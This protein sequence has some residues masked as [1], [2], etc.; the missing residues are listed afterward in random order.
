M[1]PELMNQLLW[2][3]KALPDEY[4]V[5]DTETTGLFDAQGAPGIVSL[6]LALVQ[7]KKIYASEEFLIQP[8]RPMNAEAS[9]INGI[10]QEQAQKHPAFSEQ[11][12]KILPWLEKRLVVIHNASFDWPL[13]VDHI[14]RYKVVTPAITGVFCSQRAAQ[15]W[16]QSVKIPCSA[17]GPSLDNLTQYL[18][19]DNQ[20]D[21][22]DGKHGAQI[23]AIQTA[24]VV[25]QLQTPARKL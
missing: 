15:P 16:A 25:I 6:G 22:Q 12:P 20:R 1:T 18:K 21:N 19:L 4:I 3:F 13:I 5:V 10:T 9:Q 7:D 23:D 8:H 24:E 14:E 2:P 17:R 11:W